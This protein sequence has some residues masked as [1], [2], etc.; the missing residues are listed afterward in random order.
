MQ[1]ALEDEPITIA[2]RLR[3]TY[4]SITKPKREGGAGITPKHGEW[5]YVES[6]FALHDLKFNKDWIRDWSSKKFLNI[7][8]LTRIRDVFGEKIAFYFAFLQSYSMFLLFPAVFGFSCWLL[9]GQYSAIYAIFNCLW[10]VTFVEYWKMQQKDLAVQWGVKGV[11]QIQHPR[12][13][14]KHEGEV[15]DP[16]TGETVKLYSPFKR[17]TKQLLT[18]PFAL[19]AATVLGG[20]IATCFGIEIFISEVYSG[21]FKSYLVGHKVVDMFAIY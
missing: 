12:P 16:I 20:L 3:L 17:L 19:T 7:D 9:L 14:F 6:V 18:I 8:D 10:C 2:E 5:E 21:P 1:K 4:L 13:Q 11:S 15:Q